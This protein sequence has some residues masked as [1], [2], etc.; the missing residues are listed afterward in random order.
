MLGELKNFRAQTIL[1]LESK[2]E[3][4]HKSVHKIFH[5]CVKLIVNNSDINK[6]FRSIHQ[7]AIT[8]I[9]KIFSDDWIV[10]KIVNHDIF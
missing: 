6:A 2:K 7:S 3:H 1:V 10:K 4:D 9:K 5:W 8:K